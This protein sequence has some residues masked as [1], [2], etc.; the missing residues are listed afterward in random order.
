MNFCLALNA[1]TEVIVKGLYEDEDIIKHIFQGKEDEICFLPSL[2]KGEPHQILLGLG[3]EEELTAEKVR[4]AYAG[5]VKKT[6]ECK[7]KTLTLEYVPL[8]SV[9]EADFL[10]ALAEGMDLADYKFDK[11]KSDTSDKE[12]AEELTVFLPGISDSK[13]NLEILAETKNLVK[14][15]KTARDMIAEPTNKL[16]PAEFALRAEQLAEE[17]GFEI[18]ILEE[19]EIKALGME[20]F[21]A[22]AKGSEHKPRF[23]IM[24]YLNGGEKEIL[25]LVGK[26]LTCDTGGYSLKSSESLMYMK[27]D[28]SGAA[29]MLAVMSTIAANKC[30]VNVVAAAACCENT[31][32]GGSY[33]PGDIVG[34]MA[35]KNIEVLNTDAEGRLTLADAL[36]YITEK[37]H[38]AKVIDMATLTGLA[39]TSFGSVFTPVVTNNQEFLDEFLRAAKRADEDFWQM[40]N[41]KRYRKMIDSRIAD[42]KNTGAAGTITAAMFL[43]EFVQEKPWIHLDIAGTAVIDPSPVNYIPNG[44]S[45]AAVRTIYELIKGGIQ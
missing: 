12:E 32:S 35:G 18:E 14:S 27:S 41:D 13:E 2:K 15:I 42:I 11:Y 31:I 19:D 16:F 39:G 45:G 38:A 1:Q 17:N 3:K 26:G 36:Y 4:N 43:Q 34:S 20:A 8:C 29:N 25:G 23:L 33:K 5:A 44:P 40:P 30:R 6:R 7:A 9:P 37:E 10:K 28:M 22:V 24:R 21:L